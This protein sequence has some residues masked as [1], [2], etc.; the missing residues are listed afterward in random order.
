MMQPGGGAG[1][2]RQDIRN[3]TVQIRHGTAQE[4]ILGTGFVVSPGGIVVTCAHVLHAMGINPRVGN[5]A[6]VRVYF[7]H[8]AGRPAELRAASI[9]AFFAETDDDVVCLQVHG[10][11]PLPLDRVAILGTAEGS[12]WHVFESYGYRRLAKYTCGLA[13]GKILGEVEPPGE[14]TL[15]ADPVQLESSQINSGM[16]GAAVLDLDRNL[17]V[18]IVSETWAP[19]SDTKDRDTAWAVNTSVL[20]F[21]D[22]GIEI[23]QKPLSL[24]RAQQPALKPRLV[25]EP[26][27]IAR[28]R[29][30][31]APS[32]L[33][34]WIG[35]DRLQEILAREWRNPDRLVLGLIGFGG[36]GKSS[37]ARRW[38]DTLL[39]ADGGADAPGGVLWWSFADRGSADEF[40]EA[41]LEFMSGRI[42]SGEVA[43]T[44]SR[45]ELA[46][47]LLR[48][49]RYLFILDG[50]EAVQFQTGDQYGSITSPDLLEF[51]GY[52]ATPGHQSFCLITSRAPVLDLAPYV[53]YRHVDVLPLK[54]SSGCQLLR[55]LGVLGTE[56]ALEQVVRDWAGHALTLSLLA[57][58]LVKRHGGDIRRISQIPPPNT[59]LP[60]EEMVRRVLH[61][62]DQCLSEGE[63]AFLTRFSVFRRA[64]TD[65]GLR[66]VEQGL[67]L[68]GNDAVRG[69]VLKHLV[70]ARILRSDE[71][72]RLGMHPLIRNYYVQQGEQDQGAWRRLHA[73]AK[74]YYLENILAVPNRP[75][76]EDLAPAIEAVHHACRSGAHEEASD[77]VNDHL[78]QHDRGLITRELNAYEATLSVLL[79]FFPQQD[80]RHDPSAA[81][82]QSRGWILHEVA[83]CLQLLGRL[84][85][86]AAMTRRAMQE[87]KD[88]GKWHDAAVSCQNM[89]ELYF[90]LGALPACVALVQEAFELAELGGDR[91]DEL[92][93]ETLRGALAHF[94][95][96]QEA[97]EA[98]FAAALRLARDFTPIP[99]LYSSSGVRYA[100]HLRRSGRHADA[101]TVT[102]TNLQICRTAGWQADEGRC[103]VIVGDLALDANDSDTAIA[104]YDEAIRIAHGITRRDIYIQALLGHARWANHTD[105]SDAALSDLEHAA[106][107]ATLG[108]YRLAEIDAQVTLAE[109]HHA[110]GDS[111]AAWEKAAQAEQMSL[112]IGYHW[113]QVDARVVM[114]RIG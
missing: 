19:E 49:R 110:M 46:A 87:F 93:A 75:V 23:R 79:D 45:A 7:P 77:L 109:T 35:R 57:A 71:G 34:E 22:C 37:V 86:S 94:D 88:R 96:R 60:R 55:N 32:P 89:T 30:D 108:G 16:S 50:L 1:V 2:L 100:E 63:R 97:A 15:L 40:L 62:Y 67:D 99:A 98:A 14:F 39:E 69:Y 76:L 80:I 31:N 4:L 112:E 68:A 58:Y 84:R 13:H 48:T 17:V 43:E 104:A 42:T 92:V 52:Y 51:L 91:E 5:G 26:V 12:R 74:R 105:R 106:S 11:L 59:G 56:A 72:G 103:H 24:R 64:V 8:R 101:L 95:G 70:V 21:A 73:E 27:P 102:R 3:F 36:E 10:A 90:S 114:G 107:L 6:D 61:E 29:L 33:P 28:H 47:S 78:Y 113:G 82:V 38:V 53:T 54:L 18:G 41:A 25:L 65:A 83:T 81:D 9:A 85:E 111:A 66:I 20:H 44:G